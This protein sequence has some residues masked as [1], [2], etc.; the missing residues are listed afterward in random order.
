M[1]PKATSVFSTS[2]R[3]K[4]GTLE[5]VSRIKEEQWLLP[6]VRR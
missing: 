4:P 2:F 5:A 3:N 6:V 1:N